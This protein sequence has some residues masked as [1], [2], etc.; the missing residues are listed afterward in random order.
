MVRRMGWLMSAALTLAGTSGCGLLCDRYCDR[1]HDRWIRF[2]KRSQGRRRRGVPPRDGPAQSQDRQ[3]QGADAGN[4]EDS[5]TL[6]VAR[7]RFWWW[8]F[9]ARFGHGAL[10]LNGS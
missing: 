9:V 1:F 5:S 10:S 6:L 8:A 2:R 3:H 4:E 7:W